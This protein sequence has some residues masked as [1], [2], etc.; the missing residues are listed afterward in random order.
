RADG[1]RDARNAWSDDSSAWLWDWMMSQQYKTGYAQGWR[2][3]R[4]EAR[5]ESQKQNAES[6]QEQGP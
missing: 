2:E 6:L 5:F 3:G 1:R 4:N